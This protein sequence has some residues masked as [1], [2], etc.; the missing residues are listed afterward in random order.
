MPLDRPV[1]ALRSFR[2]ALKIH[3]HMQGVRSNIKR[4]QK[5]L[6]DEEI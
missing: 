2:A 3:P 1:K 4:L 6:K 5:R